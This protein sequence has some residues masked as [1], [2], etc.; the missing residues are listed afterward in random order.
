MA[1]SSRKINKNKHNAIIVDTN[2]LVHDPRSIEILKNDG[3]HVFIPLTV[4]SELDKIKGK[5]EIGPEVRDVINRIK[6]IVLSK[7]DSFLKIIKQLDFNFKGVSDS[8]I[9]LDKN[10]PDHQILAALNHI[11]KKQK[12]NYKTIKFVTLDTNLL[13]L[14]NV[15]MPKESFEAN[16]YETDKTDINLEDLKIQ[17]KNL[18]LDN[19]LIK[20]S[21][22]E[23]STINYFI[24]LD[25]LKRTS[26]HKKNSKS[27]KDWKEFLINDGL[28]FRNQ[29]KASEKLPNLQFSDIIID[30]REPD[31]WLPRMIGVKK[32]NRIN[33]INKGIN[34]FGVFPKSMNGQINYE[35]YLAMS[36]L[37]DRTIDLVVL[38]G[39]T[40]SGKTLLALAAALEQR[41]TC[42]NIVIARPIVHVE[43][44]DALGFLPGDLDEKMNP[45]LLP[46]VQN[47]SILQ[48]LNNNNSR[49]QK[50]I[51]EY[52]KNKEE[53]K[54]NPKIIFQSISHIRGQNLD[55][56]FVIVDEAQNLSRLQM[57]TIITRLGE[58][59]KLVLTG[60]LGQIDR[61]RLLNRDNSGLAHVIK[62]MRGQS[63]VGIVIFKQTLRS[64]LAAMADKL[65]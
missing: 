35:Q 6:D 47:L 60:D 39:A 32:E 45:W 12:D 62:K 9:L 22:G 41:S 34:L 50:I 11:Y 48:S 37:T 49:Y 63:N 36:L 61:K 42:H 53:K 5:K 46:I 15:L 24:N 28:I 13:I 4:I 29:D 43:D 54:E 14:C 58:N 33:L 1:E 21:N 19:D 64:K 8:E 51:D 55:K 26:N 7:N 18:D 56:C 59:S 30:P 10:K 31:K 20:Q 27:S 25:D 23:L 38:Q 52:L 16:E 44:D 17:E 3:N 57:K 40:G 2:V 65:L